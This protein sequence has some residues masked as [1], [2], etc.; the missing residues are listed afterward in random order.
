MFGYPN[1]RLIV[2]FCIDYQ[3]VHALSVLPYLAPVN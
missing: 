3:F 2:I 1:A